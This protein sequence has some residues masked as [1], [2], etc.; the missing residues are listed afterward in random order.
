[1]KV[2]NAL[3][4]Q[5]GLMYQVTAANLAGMTQQQSL[6]QPSPGGNCANWILGHL[7][8]VQNSAM[9]VLGEKPVWENEQLKRAGYDPIESAGG[10]IQWDAMRDQ[11]LGS[12]ER[13]VAAVA[14]LADEKL[15]DTVPHPFG[16]TCTRGE[17]LTIFAFHQTY[18]AGQLAVCRRI[19]GLD[20]AIKA[21]GQV[22]AE[23]V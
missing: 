5:F 11:F 19:A 6:A 15:A 4:Q 13:C 21:P 1:M 7:T 8:N 14:A 12:R 17:L 18:H 23:K 16:G 22:Q 2:Q 20:G 10:A 9:Q 3:A